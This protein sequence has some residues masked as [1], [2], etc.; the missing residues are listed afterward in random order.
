M[1]VA[2]YQKYFINSIVGTS[3]SG[4]AT[5]SGVSP[6]ADLERYLGGYIQ[7]RREGGGAKYLGPRL[8][9]GPEIFIKHLV[10]GLLSRGFGARN[11]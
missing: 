5:L 2:R 6:V 11:V 10:I 3:C 7:G 1:L 4:R 9:W 8:V